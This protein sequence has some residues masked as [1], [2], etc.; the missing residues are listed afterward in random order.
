MEE[1]TGKLTHHQ[2]QSL[3]DFNRSGAPLVEIVTE[4]DFDSSG[5]VKR[6]L[7]ELHTII[8]YLDVSDANMEQG[9]MRL[10][11]NISVRKPGEEGFPPYKVEVKNINS[12]SFVKKA[13]DFEV[14][15]QTEI[16][17]KGETPRQETRGYNE[18]KG[19]TVSQRVK[20]EAADY[21]YF[22]EPDIPPFL[23]D[24]SCIDSIEV[25]E[26]PEEKLNRFMSEYQLKRDD[27]FLLTRD[28]SL[29]LYFESVCE[30]VAPEVSAQQVA[31]YINN[32]KIPT[33]IDVAD[34]VKKVKELSAP[35]KTDTAALQ[36]AITEV[37]NANEKAVADFRAGKEASLMFLLGQVMRH[38]KGQADA[39]TVRQSLLTALNVNV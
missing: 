4:A 36:A 39:Q 33:T 24:P 27:A 34:F 26:L 9:S 35:K 20:E 3:V 17:K 22:P 1:D 19:E 10:E 29:A 5:D 6:F 14:E 37:M 21:R 32:K 16:L 25:L 15:R 38:M 13:I 23:L 31:N 11:P 8:R 18:A 12:F 2:S 28:L 30:S 7:E